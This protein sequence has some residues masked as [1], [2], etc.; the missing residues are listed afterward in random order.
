M[1]DIH[2]ILLL[3][4]L[5]VNFS[6]GFFWYF[7]YNQPIDSIFLLIHYSLSYDSRFRNPS[8][9]SRFFPIQRACCDPVGTARA[10]KRSFRSL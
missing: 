2:R 9:I 10:G 1:A 5:L 7:F 6:S 3:L 4:L 8:E